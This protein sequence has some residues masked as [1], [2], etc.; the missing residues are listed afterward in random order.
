MHKL[1]LRDRRRHGELMAKLEAMKSEP[2]LHVPEG[3]E[4]GADP[5]EDDKYRKAQE[6]FL[7][8]VQEIDALERKG[9][10]GS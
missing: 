9:R 10:E 8:I 5:E 6:A 7:E 1:G 4:V 2:Y 3:Y